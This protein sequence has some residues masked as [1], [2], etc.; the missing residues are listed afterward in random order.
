MGESQLSATCP[1]PG[2][3]I[4]GLG[5]GIGGLGIGGLGLGLGV[6]VGLG[7][8]VG[9]GE[10]PPDA[11][12]EKLPSSPEQPETTLAHKPINSRQHAREAPRISLLFL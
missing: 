2:A 1:L 8:G 3:G 12:E 5:L 6:G 11:V 9:A 10:E 7:L 4:G